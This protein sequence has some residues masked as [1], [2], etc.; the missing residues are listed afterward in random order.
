MIV[1]LAVVNAMVAVPEVSIVIFPEESMS[2]DKVS[3]SNGTSVSNPSLM[4]TEASM[5]VVAESRFR[6]SGVVMMTFPLVSVDS[7]R[8]PLVAD[9]FEF[10]VPSIEKMPDESMSYVPTTSMSRLAPALMSNSPPEVKARVVAPDVSMVVVAASI[11]SVEVRLM[12]PVAPVNE[13]SPPDRIRSPSE[14][15][16]SPAAMERAVM[17]S[18]FP[19]MVNCPVPRYE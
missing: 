9:M 1:P 2:K 10:P 17:P 14:R 15:T 3:M 8:F 4:A 11:L 19:E 18:A 12:T 13:K 7:V 5:V 6:M 16:T